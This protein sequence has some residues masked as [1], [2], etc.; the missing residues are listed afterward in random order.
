MHWDSLHGQDV[1]ISLGETSVWANYFDDDLVYH[2]DVSV[3]DL[4][5]FLRGLVEEKEDNDAVT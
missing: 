5:A 3:P 1:I 4:A 2:E